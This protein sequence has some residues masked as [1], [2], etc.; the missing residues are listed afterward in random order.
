VTIHSRTPDEP[1]TRRQADGP[2]VPA[3]R[4]GDKN[5]REMQDPHDLPFPDFSYRWPPGR[6][7]Y[8]IVVDQLRGWQPG[9]PSVTRRATGNRTHPR[10]G[11]RPGSR[12]MTRTWK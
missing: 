5:T 7:E 12:T 4:P 1:G 10:T 3:Q 6:P 9:Q 2:L 8:A 11:A